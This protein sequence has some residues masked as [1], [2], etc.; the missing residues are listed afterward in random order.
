MCHLL[1]PPKPGGLCETELSSLVEDYLK[2]PDI[3][4]FNDT[5]VLLIRRI[6]LRATS[7]Q[8]VWFVSTN[9]EGYDTGRRNIGPQ[10]WFLACRYRSMTMEAYF[11]NWGIKWILPKSCLID[12]RKNQFFDFSIKSIGKM[13]EN[14][15]TTNQNPV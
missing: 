14:W 7:C 4:I 1:L 12:D 2:T 5:P 11:L 9:Q 8:N 6:V 15:E 10:Y 13:V 3:F